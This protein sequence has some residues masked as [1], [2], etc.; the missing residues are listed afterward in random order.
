MEFNGTT[1]TQSL[2]IARFLAKQYHLAGKSLME[3]AQ[4]DM[5]VDCVADVFNSKFYVSNIGSTQLIFT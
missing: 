5:I 4:A 2:T 1:I 3:E